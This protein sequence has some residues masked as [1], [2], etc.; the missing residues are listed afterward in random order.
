MNVSPL[1][2]F[3]ESTSLLLIENLFEQLKVY[4]VAEYNLL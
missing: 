3:D 1:F 4:F 2:G